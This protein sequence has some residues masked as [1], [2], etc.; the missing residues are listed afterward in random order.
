M[1]PLRKNSIKE[2]YSKAQFRTSGFHEVL[3]PLWPSGLG[4]R[5]ALC[6]GCTSIDEGFIGIRDFR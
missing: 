5:K 3:E 2:W 4:S 1:V 6:L